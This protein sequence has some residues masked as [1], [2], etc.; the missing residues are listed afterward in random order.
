VDT[1]VIP[2]A[3]HQTISQLD[4]KTNRGERCNHT[5]RQ[6]V[7]WRGRATISFSKTLSHHLLGAIRSYGMYD[8]N[9]TKSAVLP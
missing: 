5:I 1:G 9:L 6:W 7:S 8:E 4:R 3:Q 2:S